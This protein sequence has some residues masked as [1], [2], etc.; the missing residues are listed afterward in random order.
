MIL[1]PEFKLTIYYVAS[2]NMAT[3]R[4]VAIYLTL[5]VIKN[6][7]ESLLNYKDGKNGLN[8]IYLLVGRYSEKRF[9]L[10]VKQNLNNLFAL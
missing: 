6:I 5:Y 7:N 9:R 3:L 1:F 8:I 4:N 2:K 10:F